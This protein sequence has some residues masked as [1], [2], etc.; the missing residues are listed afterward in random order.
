MNE[1]IELNLNDNEWKLDYIDHDRK[2]VRAIIFDEDKNYYFL[3]VSRNDDFGNTVTIETSGGGVEEGETLEQAL[4][5]ELKEELGAE[6]EIICK[7]G[8][9]SDYFNLI[10]RHNIINYFLC[11]LS[12]LGKTNMTE[13]EINNFD[14][15]PL[16]LSYDDAITEYKRCKNSKIGRLIYNREYPILE[17]AGKILTSLEIK[18]K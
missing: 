3:R 11:K 6:V 13:E 8:I 12:A 7:L 5:R 1:L 17:Y 9:V 18:S 2:I 10:H 14:I 16:K 15:S 4:K